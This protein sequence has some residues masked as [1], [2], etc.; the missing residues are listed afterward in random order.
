[1]PLVIIIIGVSGS[2]KTTIGRL[3]AAR[4]GWEF[5]DADDLHSQTNRDKMRRGVALTDADRWPW[6]H[7]VRAV[8]QQCLDQHRSAVI[9]CS[10]LKQSY[11][12]LL[13]VDPARVRFVYLKG[14]RAL[15]MERLSHRTGHFFDAHLLG[16]Q[17]DTL[18][19]PVGALIV[20]IARRPDE[21]A[22][23]IIDR[24]GRRT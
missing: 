14:P 2:G 23:E 12:D 21:I 6:L 9:A 5:H 18:E 7:A 20:D 16:S 22:N 11:R 1:M 3:L 17:L 10:A 15:I 4:L 24:I 13:M 8:V 19:E